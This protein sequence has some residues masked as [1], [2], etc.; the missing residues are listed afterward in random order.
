MKI[1]RMAL[2]GLALCV[3]AGVGALLYDGFTDELGRA[4]VAIVLG[5]RV[6]HDGRPSPRLAARLDKAAELYRAGL[7]ANVIVSGGFG[8]EGF[9]EAVVMRAYL[10]A[11]GVPA[12]AVIA[13]SAGVDTAATARNSAA[14]MR[15]HQ[16]RS[17][18]IVTQYFHITRTRLALRNSGVATLYAAHA[19][20]FEWRD[21]YSIAREAVGIS[22]YWLYPR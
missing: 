7:F 17:A 11:R 2:L 20:W 4:D 21:L 13:D 15:Q 3:A 1:I 5:S 9:D 6:E 14:L 18:L 19:Q 10:V 16:W 12:A 8:K 22:V